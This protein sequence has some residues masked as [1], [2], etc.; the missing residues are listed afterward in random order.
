MMNALTASSPPPPLVAAPRQSSSSSSGAARRVVVSQRA[1]RWGIY[2]RWTGGL[3]Q[4]A[5]GRPLAAASKRE[6][7]NSGASASRRI[8]GRALGS[9]GSVAAGIRPFED[10]AAAAGGLRGGAGHARRHDRTGRILKWAGDALP[11]ACSLRRWLAATVLVS[12]TFYGFSLTFAAAHDCVYHLLA[13]NHFLSTL[14]CGF[15]LIQV[16][17]GSKDD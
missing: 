4:T 10:A 15:R 8:G 2:F 14:N 5:H 6:V 3:G 12:P 7:L 17:E 9:A 11:A 16:V 13:P 1:S